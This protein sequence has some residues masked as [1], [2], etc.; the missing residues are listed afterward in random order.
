[1]LAVACSTDATKISEIDGYETAVRA[2]TAEDALAFINAFPSSHLVGDLIESLPPAVALQTCFDMQ[3][4][5]KATRTCQHVREIVATNPAVPS[6]PPAIAGA[7]ADAPKLALA[8]GKATA[9]VK[10]KTRA[11]ASNHQQRLPQHRNTAVQVAS[12]DPAVEIAD[13]LST[14]GSTIRWRVEQGHGDRGGDGGDG[15]GGHH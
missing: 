6:A 4:R 13:T 8:S 14:S 1:M 10:P 3:N 9:D 2:Q 5:A 12:V 15:G 7:A 11:A